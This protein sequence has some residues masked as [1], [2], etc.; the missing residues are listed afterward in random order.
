MS[1]SSSQV[2]YSID[3]L[4]LSDKVYFYIKDL[5]LSGALKG[6]ERIPEETVA[7]RFGVSRTPIREALKRLEEYGLI[8]VKPRS[9]AEVISISYEEAK[10]IAQVRA[11]LESLGVRLLAKHLT[12]E[13]IEVLNRLADECLQAF[14]AN[15]KAL[16]FEKDSEFHL[17]I[18]RRSG[19]KYLYDLFEKLDAKVQLLRLE[20]KLPIDTLKG[21]VQEHQAILDS[22]S[23]G[24][25]ETAIHQMEKHIIGQLA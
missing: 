13:D 10:E 12:A 25:G 4:S 21:F 17:E 8:L 5:I 3:R 6:G 22:L 15:N 7:Q 19:N 18:S 1:I 24:D 23:A 9:Y 11:S 16:G 20:L 14:N 2:E